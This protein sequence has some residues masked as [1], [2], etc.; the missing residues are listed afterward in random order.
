NNSTISDNVINGTTWAGIL[1]TGTVPNGATACLSQESGNTITGNLVKNVPHEGIQVACGSNDI[2]NQNN[3]INAGTAGSGD[4][5]GNRNSAISLYNS[6]QS[7]ISIEGNDLV[8]SFQGLTIGQFGQHTLGQN[9]AANFNAIEGNSNAEVGNY[10][11][12]GTLDASNNW[13]GSGG[14]TDIATPNGASTTTTP[15]LESLTLA[16]TGGTVDVGGSL[17]LT[18]TLNTSGGAAAANSSVVIGYTVS[19]GANGATVATVYQPLSQPFTFS[20]DVPGTYTVTAAVLFGSQQYGHLSLGLS[21]TA[22]ITVVTPVFGGGGG[23][24]AA[25]P[26]VTPPPSTP[27]SSPGPIT[28]GSG[29]TLTVTTPSGT[30]V[31]VT[32]PAG[33]VKNTVT[34]QVTALST[35]PSTVAPLAHVVLALNMSAKTS[36]GVPVTSFHAPVAIQFSLPSPPSQ[37]ISVVYWNSLLGQWEPLPDV[38]IQGTNVTVETTHF[39]TFAVVP[40]TEISLVQRLAGTSRVGTAIAAA[41]AAYPDGTAAVVLANEGGAAPS[42]DALAAAGLAGALGAPVLL[43]AASH[44]SNGV[45]AA[46]QAL[47]AKTVYVVGGPAAVSDQA[48]AALTGAGLTVVRQFEGQDRFQTAALIDQYLYANHLTQSS[49]AFLANG[50]T[51]VDALSASPVAYRFAA[52]MILVNSGQTALPSST[53]D[54][55]ASAGIKRVVI[56]GLGAAVAPGV[57]MQLGQK[58]GSQAVVRL[59]GTTRDGTAVAIDQYFFTQP[60]GVVIAANGAAG[61][62]F[63]DA[64]SASA[65]AGVNDM[66]ILLANP[67]S[68]PSST[69]SYLKSLTGLHAAWVMGGPAA[70]SATVASQV[71]N[72]VSAP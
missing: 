58:L 60:A 67:G 16:P 15:Y 54:W 56:L 4:T 28:P 26:P 42:P 62:T 2:V 36:T 27:P 64:L 9:V 63:V 59:G 39:T 48:V 30:T 33:A 24:G 22:T 23:G 37:P 5:G 68:L 17:T 31:T 61:S 57:E 69:G 34:A 3:V 47:G 65:M 38:T 14:P 50:A 25:P 10:A 45:L 43:T 40:A 70:L 71:G 51:M 8:N 53:L 49:T 35:I 13:W 6:N 29:G 52:P 46:I 20:E 11:T 55:L 41:E 44:L 21:T 32:V 18:P 19:G 1:L 12:S 66:P 7:N 72:Y